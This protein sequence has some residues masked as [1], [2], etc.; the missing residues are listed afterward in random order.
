MLFCENGKES[1]EAFEDLVLFVSQM[2]A[3]GVR[4]GIG[5][6][7]IPKSLNRNTQFDASPYILGATPA[8]GQDLF[9]AR[10]H[11]I[12]DRRLNALRR[13]NIEP[14]TKLYA[15]GKF[16]NFQA[17][18]GIK[19]KLS[20]VLGDNPDVLD[21]DG[22]L[23]SGSHHMPVFGV[24]V[25]KAPRRD[26]RP[27]VMLMAPDLETDE[28]QIA[29]K[30]LSLSHAFKI[31][32]V[33]DGKSKET[34]IKGNG[35]GIPFYQ[36]SE[37]LPAAL[38]ARIDVAMIYMAPTNSY[39][40]QCLLANLVTSGVPI[41]DCNPGRAYSKALDALM[42]G[43][44]D[45]TSTAIWLNS[46]ALPNMALIAREASA[47][48]FAKSVAMETVVPAL[49]GR[50]PSAPRCIKRSGAASVLFVPTNGVGL[51]HAQRCSLIASEMD[52]DLGV[53][54]FAAF[55]SCMRM[56]KG[57]GFEVMPMISRSSLHMQE[58]END[59]LNYARLKA[60]S[61]DK[62]TLVFD[63]G[64]VF[65][66][67]YRSIV[68]N[69]LNGVWVRRGMWQ[70]GQDNSIALD[71]EKVFNRVIVPLEAFEELNEDYSDGKHLTTVGPIVQSISLTRAKRDTIRA[72]IGRQFGK[73]FKHLVVTMLGGGVAADRSS[74][75][76][77]ICAMVERRAD[78]LNLVVV[79]PT[80]TVEAGAFSWSNSRVV[81]THHASA[82]VAACDLYISAVG[83]NSFHEAMYNRIP[84]IF[85]AQM[86]AFMDDQRARAMAAIN[87][88]LADIV[89]PHEMM[90]LSVKLAE[91][92]DGGR[93]NE[94]RT[95]LSELKL[96]EAGNAA[97]AKLIMEIS[98]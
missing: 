69:N 30:A 82:L 7:S 80:A 47:S 37:L 38:T 88:N 8:S 72:A 74:Q 52:R 54:T 90:S 64:Y 22:G 89:E 59:L 2:N 49:T 45:L 76:A 86:N 6:G 4:A 98:Q 24:K 40:I 10:A 27:V 70:K 21:I 44:A 97:A 46:G 94:I 53:P 84:T 32:V 56:L 62:K 1:P 5:S 83:Y 60:L 23:V 85:M 17:V 55:P 11:E 41:V 73:T 95:R 15:A 9:I 66:S 58:H 43:P 13:M 75:V 16:P 51:G 78:T 63:G 14:G 28:Q 26:D 77:S 91:F 87:R 61:E 65:D 68:E 79:W 67:I 92:L 33:T 35:I 48:R 93:S 20:Y 50:L 25:D 3:S 57:Y 29:L 12:T 34:W 18:I 36:Y 96:P 42:Q 31:V 71:R 39:R 81:K 19:S